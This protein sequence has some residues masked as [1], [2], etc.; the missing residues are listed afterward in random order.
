[1]GTFVAS[2]EMPSDD[3]YLVQWSFS[4][5]SG[6]V[7]LSAFNV[8]TTLSSVAFATL[9]VSNLEAFDRFAIVANGSGATRVTFDAATGA[10]LVGTRQV[11]NLGGGVGD[12][13]VLSFIPAPEIALADIQRVIESLGWTTLTG[14][15]GPL[16]RFFVYALEVP[17]RLPDPDAGTGT[18]PTIET[19]LQE[20]LNLPPLV[21]GPGEAVVASGSQAARVIYNVAAEWQETEILGFELAGP[22]AARFSI[23]TTGQLRFADT[24]LFHAPADSGGDNIYDVSIRARDRLMQLSDPLALR[25]SVTETDGNSAATGGVAITSEPDFTFSMSPL[26]EDADGLGPLHFA[27]QRRDPASGVWVDIADQTYFRLWLG[28]HLA[29]L[30]LRGVVRFNDAAGH[31]EEIATATTLQRGDDAANLLSAVGGPAVL[32]GLGGDDTLIGGEGNDTLNGGTGNDTL[33]GGAGN[34]TYVIDALGDVI[35]ELAGEGIDSVIAS[36]NHTLAAPLENLTLA[37]GSAAAFA[38]GNTANNILI[39]NAGTDTLIG[40][41]GNDTLDGGTEADFL[42]GGTG[43]DTYLVDSGLDTVD[44]GILQPSLGFGGTDTIVSTANFFWDVYSVAEVIRLAANAADPTGAG[45]TLVG[46]VFNNTLIGNAAR[47]VLF[48]RGGSD[49][50][51]AGDGVDFMSLSTLGVTDFGAYT[52]NGVN[53]VLVRPRETG[54]VSWDIVFE[55]EPGRDKLDLSLYGLGSG[56]AALARFVDTGA[57]SYAQLGDGGD[58]LWLVNLNKAALSAGDF[59]V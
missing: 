3:P 28:E 12:D 27:W 19:Y 20:R 38:V 6:N 7:H 21:S 57:S 49:I 9:R 1:V 31:A 50:Y 55:F 17:G 35:T 44:E 54:P 29:G 39:G 15:P 22:D 51:D 46:G 23:T 47:N 13:L 32:L 18:E 14:D 24:P 36:L 30:T 43:N 59:I 2:F 5:A 37:A 16:P 48:G 53:T 10:V 11:A 52:A 56:A 4:I 42:F 41:A 33:V 34:D 25:I 8:E 26:L 58:V 45:S 40:Y